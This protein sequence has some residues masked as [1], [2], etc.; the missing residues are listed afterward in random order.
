M[1]RQNK[2]VNNKSRPRMTVSSVEFIP[3]PDVE[4]RLAKVYKLLLSNTGQEGSSTRD[5][6]QPTKE[7]HEGRDAKSSAI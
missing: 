2:R 3:T 7:R 1:P 5:V 4:Q 6:T